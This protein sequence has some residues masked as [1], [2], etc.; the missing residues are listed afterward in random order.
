MAEDKIQN[1]IAKVEANPNLSD[2]HRKEL[3]ELL[4]EMKKEINNLAKIDSDRASSIASFT[5]ISTN[6]SMREETKKDVLDISLKG[7]NT[8]IE[9]FEVEHP[10]L[11]SIV[12]RISIMLSNLGI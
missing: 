7:L 9:D 2:E 1:L 11:V 3:L 6:E 4:E 12:N 8:S 5:E 10:Q